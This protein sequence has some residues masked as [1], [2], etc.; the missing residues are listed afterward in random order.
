MAAVFLLVNY[1]LFFNYDNFIYGLKDEVGHAVSGH[2]LNVYPFHHWFGFHLVNS[3]IPGLS[4]AV[5]LLALGGLA[6]TVRQWQSAVVADKLLFVYTLVFYFIHELIPMKAFP[7]Y[8][9]YMIPIAPA[10]IYFA[11]KAIFHISQWMRGYSAKPMARNISWVLA[12]A[13]VLAP[14]YDTWMIDT[15]LNNDTRSKVVKWIA[16]TKE[17]VWY[18]RYTMDNENYAKADLTAIDIPTARSS[19]V[20]Y[21]IAS[22]F[23]YDRFFIGSQWPGQPSKVY[24]KSKKYN[25]LFSFPYTE[26]KPAYKTFA[27]SNPVIRIIDIRGLEN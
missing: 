9:R 11:C 4:L 3:L 10:M 2:T 14:F 18:E 12:G 1:P 25:R 5:T 20:A 13:V 8:M 15:N 26:I 17:K 23:N 7:D 27:F 19:G 6:W 21:L 24:K 16:S 22:S